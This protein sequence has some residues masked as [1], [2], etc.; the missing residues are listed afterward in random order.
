MISSLEP[1]VQF[2]PSGVLSVL[3]DTMAC[4]KVQPL[5]SVSLKSFTRI[6]AACADDMATACV[7]ASVSAVLFNVLSGGIVVQ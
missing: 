4:R 6:V 2:E 1:A 5:P 7:M 3:A